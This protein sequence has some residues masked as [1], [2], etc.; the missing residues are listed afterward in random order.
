MKTTNRAPRHK[1][2]RRSLLQGAGALGI[3]LP[4]L[5]SIVRANDDAGSAKRLIVFCSPNEPIERDHWVPS[6]QGNAFPLTQLAPVMSP[7]EPHR[8]KLTMV[9]DLRMQSR[10]DDPHTG[11]HIGMVHLL[12][13]RRCVPTGSNEPNQWAGG[14]SL[15]QYVANARGVQALTLG[16]RVAQN[17]GNSRISFTGAS[18]PVDPISAPDVAFDDLFADA[19][20]PA[21]ERAALK[22]QRLSVLDR[23]TGDIQRAKS[24]LPTEA[25]HKLDIH[26]DMVRE[27]ELALE[28]DKL[29]ECTPE[30]PGAGDYNSNAMFPTTVRRQIDVMVQALGCGLTDVASLQLS[31]SGASNITP[32]WPDEGININDHYHYLAHQYIESP[33]ASNTSRRVDMER[34]LFSLF[35]YL[36]ERLDSIPEGTGGTMLD[37]SIVVWMKPLG[38]R[39]RVDKMLFMLAGGA[40]GQL[41]TGRFVSFPDAPHNNLLLEICHLMGLQDETFGDPS[42]CT[43]PLSL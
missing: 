6:G 41:Q 7:L 33:N 5:S 29:I 22:A 1:L 24:R 13:G 15:D 18:Q 2:S 26:S 19:T 11:G 3:G 40:N 12:V 34:Y 37:S 21:E 8:D 35:A 43:G 28:A 36:L 38:Y 31:N 4:F 25:R 32:M 17:N 30:S 10:L 27:L 42:Y 39:H 16:A 20:L 9:G 14:I 23:V